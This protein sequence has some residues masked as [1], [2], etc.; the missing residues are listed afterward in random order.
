MAERVLVTGAS[1]FV[2]SALCR[3]LLADGWAVRA[4]SRT[5]PAL[6]G[7]DSVAVGEIG[8]DTDWTAALAGV[9][10]IVHCAARVHRMDDTP[11]EA[12]AGHDRVNRQ[13][14]AALAAQAAAAGVKR[15]VFVSSVKAQGFDSAPQP[16]TEADRAPDLSDPPNDPYGASKL[17]AEQAL[18]VSAATSGMEAVAVR[19]VLVHGPG[20]RGNL[21]RLQQAIAKGLP[22]PI[23]AV[24]NRRSLVG[25]DNLCDL[26]SLCLHH[27]AAAGQV[28]LA[29][30]SE[31]VSS[32][33]L[34][35]SLAAAMQRRPLLLPVPEPLLRLAG[36]LLG[37]RAAI[38]RLCG[39]LEVSTAHARTVLG[40]TPP[41]TLQQGLARMVDDSERPEAA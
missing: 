16:L 2:G 33:T 12:L 37:R 39:S 20:A 5:A 18:F 22:L 14:T 36:C 26:L 27:P 35:R 25:L 4:A 15:F 10:H 30:D 1:G 11:A 32:A 19:P 6:P 23:G 28:F 9:T 34:A 40:W 29:A 31:A 17:A 7:A 21:L 24:R 8:P 13:G 41:L 38:E 3:R